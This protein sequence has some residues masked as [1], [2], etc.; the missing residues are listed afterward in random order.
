MSIILEIPQQGMER[1]PQIFKLPRRIV[2]HWLVNPPFKPMIQ[3]AVKTNVQIPRTAPAVGRA[4][5]ANTIN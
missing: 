4:G 3:P 5:L 2:V 1:A